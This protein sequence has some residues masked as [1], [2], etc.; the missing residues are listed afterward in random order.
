[1]TNKKE[2]R[3]DEQYAAIK[4]DY[5]NEIICKLCSVVELTEQLDCVG[6]IT[7]NQT[8]SELNLRPPDCNQTFPKTQTRTFEPQ[9]LGVEPFNRQ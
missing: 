9:G 7:P 1:M 8:D 5:K 3:P 4:T 6:K 2:E